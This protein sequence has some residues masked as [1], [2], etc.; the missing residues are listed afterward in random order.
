MSESRKNKPKPALAR[1]KSRAIVWIALSV[2][3]FLSVLV[4][5]LFLDRPE[6]EVVSAPVIEKG[7]DARDAILYFAAPDA[8][9]LVA[10]GRMVDGCVEEVDCVLTTVR[11]LIVGSSEALAPVLPS[12]TVVLS[13]RIDGALV[14]VDF[15]HELVSGHVGGTQSELL[16]VY[17]LANTLATNFPHLRQVRILV[18]GQPIDTLKGHVDLRQPVSPDFSLVDEEAAP[19]GGLNH[20]PT[21]SEE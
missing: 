14:E 5:F 2:V 9:L 10:E 6:P 1:L 13:A 16:S 19:I 17:A 4:T 11:A 18:E 3:L 12:Q 21:R 20:Q 7:P 8:T 15:N